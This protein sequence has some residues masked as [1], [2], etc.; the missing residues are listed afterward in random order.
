MS[1]AGIRAFTK[2]QFCAILVRMT[3]AE[4]KELMGRVLREA[5]ADPG[6][7]L[8][9]HLDP[10][11]CLCLCAMLQLALRHPGANGSSRQLA[12]QF[13]ANVRA[14]LNGHGFTAHAEAIGLGDDP[15]H[16]FEATPRTPRCAYFGKASTQLGLIDTGGNQC[17]L[18]LDAHSPCYLVV[19]ENRPP[20]WLTCRR[21]PQHVPSGAE[22]AATTEQE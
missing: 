11:N 19:T 5:Q 1:G 13:I 12:E 16:D 9:V 21:N 2:H 7:I 10:T 4:Q 18:V 20:D 22:Q 6:F 17:A 8:P 15:A 3:D 14:R